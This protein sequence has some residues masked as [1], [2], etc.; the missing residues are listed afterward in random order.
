M[1]TTFEK[2][3]RY[4]STAFAVSGKG[5]AVVA[6]EVRKLAERS[7][8]AAQ[9][10]AEFTSST[11]SLA[12]QAGLM[13]DKLIPDIG[14]TAQLV[15]DITAASKEQA[16]G[17]D[18]INSAVQQLNKV[19]QQNSGASEEISS[20]ARQLSLQADQLQNVIAFFKVEKQEPSLR[21]I[22]RHA[23]ARALKAEAGA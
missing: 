5:F 7:R 15:K 8:V 19:I 4:L 3:G 23:P 11:V 1:Q 22:Q 13:L 2:G 9:E 17:T 12:E 21:S 10:I 6:A 14:K 16:T 20:T 18:Q